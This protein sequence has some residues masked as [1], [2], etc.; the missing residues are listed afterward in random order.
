MQNQWLIK[1]QNQF[2]LLLSCRLIQRSVSCNDRLHLNIRTFLKVQKIK[3]LIINI[4]HVAF[5]YC[6]VAFLN[7][8]FSPPAIAAFKILCRNMLASPPHPYTIND[9]FCF[10]LNGKIIIRHRLVRA[11]DLEWKC[12]HQ[13]WKQLPLQKTAN[14]ITK[15]NSYQARRFRT[16]EASSL[17][18]QARR[19]LYL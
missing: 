11:T 14:P 7:C 9:I 13:P 3:C 17:A 12:L 6:H 18:L 5:L 4:G 8:W 16:T 15:I 1:F 19:S 2:S 10:Y